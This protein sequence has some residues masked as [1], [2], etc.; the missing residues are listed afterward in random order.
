MASLFIES[1]WDVFIIFQRVVQN[2]NKFQP[3]VIRNPISYLY[4]C[5]YQ[6]SVTQP[7]GDH[8]IAGTF[9]GLGISWLKDQES[10]CDFWHSCPHGKLCRGLFLTPDLIH[11]V[12]QFVSMPPLLCFS[13]FNLSW[14]PFT[15]SRLVYPL[16]FTE[17]SPYLRM[18]SRP[19]SF[20]EAGPE[21]IVIV[22]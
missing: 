1:G 11:G 12:F 19:L 9:I 2:A 16:F 17:M 4:I 15:L 6:R 5:H 7:P 18:E 10:R 13:P 22:S 14:L 3:E 8:C 20:L 21:R